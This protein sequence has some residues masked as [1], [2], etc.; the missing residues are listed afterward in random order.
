MKPQDQYF[1]FIRWEDADGLYVGYCPDN[2]HLGCGWGHPSCRQRT[3]VAVG[4]VTPPG[5]LS[6]FRAGVKYPG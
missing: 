3:A 1:K 5:P 4:R 6:N 2:S